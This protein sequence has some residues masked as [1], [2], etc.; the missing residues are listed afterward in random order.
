MVGL[1]CNPWASRHGGFSCC[2]ARAPCM[3][4]SSFGSQALELGLSSC[5]K[6]ASM[7]PGMW[8]HPRPG[9][10]SMSLALQGRFLTTGPQGKPY[11]LFFKCL[12]YN[13]YRYTRSYK[14]SAELPLIVQLVFPNGY[15][16][17][18]NPISNRKLTLVQ[19]VCINCMPF[20]HM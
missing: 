3:R 4:L 12:F 19:C 9:I 2:R 15:I 14:D 5:E 7:L 6:Q 18:Y 11:V 8:D 20:Y 1:Y 10:E 13:D 17:N 16:Y